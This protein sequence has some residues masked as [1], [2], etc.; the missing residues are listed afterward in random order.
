MTKTAARR[1]LV[2]GALLL[3]AAASSLPAP[4]PASDGRR[5]PNVVKTVLPNGLTILTLEDRSIPSVALYLYFKVGS[6]N[7]HRGITGI[8]HLFEHMMFNGS[9]RFEP[10][11]FDRIIEAG[12]GYSNGSTWWDYTNYWE[13]FSPVA[14]DKVLELEAD[15]M[16]A[17]R[18]DEQNLEQERGIVINERLLR[19]DNSVSGTLFERVWAEAFLASPYHWPVVGWLGDL[20]EGIRLEDAKRY[21]KTYYAPNNAVMVLVGDF[22]T[23]PTLEKIRRLW[24][25]V[26]S[27]E[28]PRPVADPEPPQLGEKRV[29]VHKEAQAPMLAIGYKIPGFAGARA[30]DLPAL[31]VLGTVLGEGR[32]SPLHRRLVYEKE[33]CTSASVW[34]PSFAMTSLATF[35]FELVPGGDTAAVEKELEGVLKKLQHEG[36]DQK[37]LRRAKNQIEANFQRGLVG[38]AGRASGLGYYEALR[39]DWKEMYRLLDAYR[40]TTVEDVVRVAKTYLVPSNRTVAILVPKDLPAAVDFEKPASGEAGPKTKGERR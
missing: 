5:F 27:A 28:A 15:R 33:L 3:A 21:F 24:A 18:L 7:E 36:A 20:R 26:P 31:E 37:D 9:E 25:N 2:A 6:R 4:I 8:S 12:G 40:K 22:A 16:R 30:A 10:K 11:S 29:V 1:S 38:N 14:L 23:A 32:S 39:G 17:L 35:F 34:V 13:E 19:T